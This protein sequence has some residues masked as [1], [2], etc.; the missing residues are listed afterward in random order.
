[1]SEIYALL[2]ECYSGNADGLVCKIQLWNMKYSGGA[3]EQYI[4]TW[5]EGIN[6]LHQCQYPYTP[7]DVAIHFVLHGPMHINAWQKFQPQVLE[8]T[9]HMIV[10][11]RWLD[12]LFRTTSLDMWVNHLAKSI[13]TALHFTSTMNPNTR[14]SNQ[15]RDSN[16]K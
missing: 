8:A 14:H 13:D 5:K 11:D 15:P 9:Q 4:T 10:H 7:E 1:M 12:K 6:H 3:V 16:V 2:S